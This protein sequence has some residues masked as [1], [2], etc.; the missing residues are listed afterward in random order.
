ME[1]MILTYC[2]QHCQNLEYLYVRSPT[3]IYQADNGLFLPKNKVHSH[4][5][6]KPFKLDEGYMEDFFKS[7]TK[8][9]NLRVLRLEN[10]HVT[11]SC[12]LQL[13]EVFRKNQKLKELNFIFEDTNHS[14]V[15]L[16][17]SALQRPCEIETLELNVKG[18]TQKCSMDL[19]DIFWR[20]Q[21]L[22]ELKLYL[23]NI[24]DKTAHMMFW[25]LLHR[26]CKV[27][28]YGVNLPK[29]GGE[30]QTSSS[31]SLSQ[32]GVAY[33][34]TGPHIRAIRAASHHQFMTV[35]LMAITSARRAGIQAYYSPLHS[36]CGYHCCLGNTS[37]RGGDMQGGDLVIS[38]IKHYKLDVFAS[39]KASVQRHVL[40]RVIEVP[41]TLDQSSTRP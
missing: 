38:I 4:R 28:N 27:K 15:E 30:H 2:I 8:L 23:Y 32:L 33:H 39:T 34:I 35:F 14:A 6:W 29:R 20:N 17:C 16:L 7:L 10:L 12:R 19:A 26:N 5:D 3:S 40:Q 21:K 25:G 9:R 13:V 31:S 37:F 24:D 41:E 36:E 1:L 22:K 11:V 18:M